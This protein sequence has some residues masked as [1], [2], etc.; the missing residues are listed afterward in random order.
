MQLPRDEASYRLSGQ[1]SALRDVPAETK[2]LR[3]A[4][5]RKIVGSAVCTALLLCVSC[6]ASGAGRTPYPQW[7]LNEIHEHGGCGLWLHLRTPD[8]IVMKAPRPPRRCWKWLWLQ[9][10]N[11]HTGPYPAGGQP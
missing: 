4:G 8:G 11:G 2:R 9:H 7:Y 1:V 5:V 6:H 3:V 10:M